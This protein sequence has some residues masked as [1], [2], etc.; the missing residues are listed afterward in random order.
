MKF[1]GFT[2]GVLLVMLL[3]GFSLSK[4]FTVVDNYN[5]VIINQPYE[6]EVCKEVTTEAGD[7]VSGAIWGAIFG[8]IVGDAIDD[9]NG[10]LPGAIIGAGIG[11]NEE[12]KKGNKTTTQT[13]CE[14]E[15]RYNQVK[16]EEYSHSTIKFTYDSKSYEIDF[17]K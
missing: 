17:I 13:V 15:T 5:E 8:A 11:A 7:E 9:E 1:I 12:K 10:R 6:V 16:S 2:I 4:G 3:S 14:T